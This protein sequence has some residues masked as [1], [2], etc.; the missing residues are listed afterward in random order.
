MCLISSHWM[1]SSTVVEV[2]R[3][4]PSSRA[5]NDQC[6]R[7]DERTA[8]PMFP[9]EGLSEKKS[10]QCHRHDDAYLAERRHLGRIPELDRSKVAEP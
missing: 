7:D 2:R 4:Y 1:N 10:S 5:R 6:P 3:A 8:G 9:R